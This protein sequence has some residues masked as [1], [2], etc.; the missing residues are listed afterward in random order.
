MLILAKESFLE[1]NS[2]W[3]STVLILV[4]TLVV[5]KLVD[6]FLTRSASRVSSVRDAEPLSKGAVTRLRL[7]HR[8]IVLAIVIFGIFLALSQIDALHSLGT[9]LLAS[10]AVI[11]VALGIA[12]RAVLANAVSGMMLATV[13]PFRI[14]DVIEWQE[15][16]GRVEDI[17]LSYTFLRLPSGH[18]LVIPND[19][20]ATSAIENYTIAGATVD[21]DAS[22]EVYPDKATPAIKLLREK[23]KDGATVSLGTC[24]VDRHEILVSFTT[25]AGHE[26]TQRFATRE[27]VVAILSDAGLLPAPVA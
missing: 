6:I 18:R 1:A 2:Q 12:A 4:V 15:K 21:A 9:A 27:Q 19:V 17:T 20:M 22:I 5:A 24:A 25:T 8:L 14:G 7:I 11:G 26:A 16:R 10:S 23:L 3:I 13:Q